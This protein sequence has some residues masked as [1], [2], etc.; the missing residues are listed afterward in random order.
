MRSAGAK[1]SSVRFVRLDIKKGA[2]VDER[3]LTWNEMYRSEGLPPRL[4]SQKSTLE[5]HTG[6]K[7]YLTLITQTDL[8]TKRAEIKQRC[9]K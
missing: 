5:R 2:H 9:G 3:L 7:S 8:I 6:T 1:L 4:S